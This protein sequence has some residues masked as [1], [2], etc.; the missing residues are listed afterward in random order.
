[1][2]FNFPIYRKYDHGKTYFRINSKENFDELMI[3]G[4][5]YLLRNNEAKIFPEFALI[6]DM[7]ENDKGHWIAIEE[8]EFN[9]VL[10]DCRE[11]LTL[12]D[13]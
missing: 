5:H 7:I 8:E 4:K 6:I 12:N 3:V 9:S 2:N 13:Y 1:M 10:E 11:N